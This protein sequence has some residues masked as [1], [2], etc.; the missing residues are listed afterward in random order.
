[1]RAECPNCETS[2]TMDR[3]GA[4]PLVGRNYSVTCGICKTAFSV[5]FIEIRNWLRRKKTEVV[6]IVVE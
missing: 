2:Y 1:M 6:V 3:L 5:S 4:E